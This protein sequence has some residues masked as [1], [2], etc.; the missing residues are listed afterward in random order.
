MLSQHCSAQCCPL[1]FQLVLPTARS[2]GGKTSYLSR[3][4]LL[5]YCPVCLHRC[6]SPPEEERLSNQEKRRI[7]L[8]ELSMQT[9]CPCSHNACCP[10]AVCSARSRHFV[11]LLWVWLWKAPLCA[12][13]C[14]PAG[15]KPPLL[16]LTLH[17]WNTMRGPEVTTVCN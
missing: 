12:G 6:N 2:S 5:L 8:P 3:T 1:Q 11:T 17:G 13:K 16:A 14:Q 10:L 7:L 15:T 9:C 4:V